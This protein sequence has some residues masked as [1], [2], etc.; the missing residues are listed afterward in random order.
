ME[1]INSS[2]SEFDEKFLA[3]YQ[4]GNTQ[5]TNPENAFDS[6]NDAAGTVAN[7]TNEA[8][9][10]LASQMVPASSALQ[11]KE[12]TDEELEALLTA[13]GHPIQ[14]FINAM[15]PNGAPVNTRHKSALKLASD[16]MI[17]FDGNERLVKLVLLKQSWVQDV[18]T[19]RGEKEI[20]DIIDSARKLL[21]KR[22][23]ESFCEL[24][25]SRE[26]QKAIEE[27]AKRKY[28]V[29]VN[30]VNNALLG[31]APADARDEVITLLER[32]G[33]EIEKLFPYFPLIR[34][35]CHRLPRKHYIAAL[36]TG[37]AFL[38]TLMTRC[39][40]RFWSAPGRR[41][42]LNSLLALIGR[43]GSGK[44]IA[45]DLYKILMEPVRLADQ[46]QVD[47]LNRW[48]TERDQNSG[49]SKNKTP[50][51]NGIYRRLPAET[52]AAGAREAETNA[53]EMI[54]GEDT[55][56]HVSQFDS[57][58]DNTLRQL[59]KSYMDA[60]FTLWLK[61]YHNEPHGSLLKTSSAYVGE[62]PVHYNAVYTGTDDALRKLATE[63]NFVNGLLSRFTFVPMGDSNFEMMKSHDYDEADAERDRQLLEWAFKLDSTKGEIPAKPISDALHQWTA[64]RMSDAEENK[65]YAE[66]DMIKRPCWHGMN[67][68]LPFVVS[69]HWDMMEEDADGRWK[70]SEAFETDAHDVQ[71]ALIIAKAQLEFQYLYFRKIGEKHYEDM[72]SE[73]ISG[74][75]HQ[76]K[77]MVGYRRLPDI[78]TSEDV[79]KCFEYGGKKGSITS[80]IKRLCDDGMAQKITRGKD[81]GKYRKLMS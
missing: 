75:R 26:M 56:L 79:D 81:K 54:D 4:Q 68:A 74:H 66:E 30:E 45:V 15:Y 71:L 63:S 73:Q 13:F 57:E 35:L 36:L 72:E 12:P 43:L 18:V 27:V 60:L 48:N 65:N 41:C 50:R 29:L 69:R 49:A 1:K 67:Y 8:A 33:K 51:P 46:P 28:S 39:W 14:D 76:P 19:E 53:H 6:D 17:L 16:L 59:K 58:L 38:M 52:S 21:K 32:L 5:P 70:C 44:H 24:R 40:Y 3:E 22:E 11:P 20:D 80:K 64:R 31:D 47:A 61:C 2:T 10:E 34:L 77:T 9:K 42:R 55:Y 62:Y 23:C 37:G 78:F 25:P 7:P